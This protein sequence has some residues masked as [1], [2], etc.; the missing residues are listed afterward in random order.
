[1]AHA[2]H[3]KKILVASLLFGSVTT[4]TTLARP[5]IFTRR[6]FQQLSSLQQKAVLHGRVVDARTGEPIAKV[7]VIAGDQSTVTNEAGV[8]TLENLP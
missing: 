5:A 2:P 7:K 6:V 8:F 1:M 3:L 4:N